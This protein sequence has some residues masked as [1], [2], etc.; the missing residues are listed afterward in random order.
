MKHR[1]KWL[2]AFIGGLSVIYSVSV[3][4]FVATCP[5]LRMRCLLED[6][7]EGKGIVIQATPDVEC[8]GP[9]P[10]PGDILLEIRRQPI[11]SFVDFTAQLVDLRN[12]PIPPGGQLYAGSDPSEL[13]PFSLP[14][15]VEDGDGHRWVEIEFRNHDTGVVENSW[16]MVQSIPLADL[17][18]TFVWFLLQL[19]IFIIGALAYW[20]RPFDRPARMFF[21]MCIVTLAGFVGGFHWWVVAGNLWLN[22]PFVICAALVPVVTLHFFLIFPHPKPHLVKRPRLV[23]TA[24]YALPVFTI[25][26]MIAMMAYLQVHSGNE[27]TPVTREA[28]QTGQH[29][30]RIVIYAY[31]LAAAVYFLLTMVALV[32]SFFTTRNPVEH[33]QVK[34][35][36]W[37]GLAATLPVSY[38]L[39]LAHFDRVGFALGKARVPMFV[40]S[41]SFMLAYAVGM[42]RFKLMLADQIISKGVLYYVVS[43]SVALGFSLI[44]ACTVIVAQLLTI[45]LSPQ[46]SFAVGAVLVMSLLL[47]LWLRDRFQQMT[48]RKFFREKYQLDKAL[49]RMNR[50]VGHLGTPDVVADRM[51]T[52]CRDVLRI[53]QAG[54]YLRTSTDNMFQLVAAQG[55]EQIPM[56]LIV[57]PE[58]I[59]ELKI[60]GTLQRITTGSRNEMSVVQSTLR[61][62]SAEL[63]HALEA[64]DD[65][66]GFVA[67]GSKDNSSA[68]TGEDVT[69]LHAMGQITHVALHSAKVHSDVT[70]LNEDL[71][72]KM[73]RIATQERHIS[74]LQSE[75]ATQIEP[76]TTLADKKEGA[77]FRRE[78][79]RGNSPAIRNVLETV[80]KVASSESTVLVRGESGTGKELLAKILHD[81]S[82]RREGPIVQVHCASLSPGLLES[83]LFGHAKGSFTGAHRDKVGRFEMA[84]RGT[85]FLDEIGDISMETQI[86]LLRVLQERCFEPVGSSRT[87]HV[88]V[89]LITATHQPLERLISEGSFR[90]DLYYRLNVISVTLPPLRERVEDIIDLALHFLKRAAHRSDKSITHIDE[91]ALAAM[92]F[93]SWPGNVRQLENVIERAVVL[94]EGGRIRLQDLPMEISA[95]LMQRSRSTLAD[96]QPQPPT[97]ISQPRRL[98]PVDLMTTEKRPSP[99]SRV[100]SQPISPV[101]STNQLHSSP[102]P[103]TAFS[104]E[105]Q[106][107][108]TT[109]RQDTLS[110]QPANVALEPDQEKEMLELALEKAEGNKAKAARMMGLPR[111]TYYSKLKKYGIR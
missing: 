19:G 14:P 63:I 42:I 26:T 61:R 46:Q 8:K 34:W 83:E 104:L 60:D 50:T 105:S 29:L 102:P 89:R 88:D 22:I 99:I 65:I 93:F 11:L 16:L 72:A 49:E 68:F 56:Q 53:E 82:P 81:N 66:I 48:D 94:A 96:A 40:A 107:D 4:G 101:P 78:A 75:L 55:S 109:N 10:V 37:A 39:F 12:A 97:S 43:W 103:M 62:L 86:K 6:T 15:L 80:R 17:M 21:V 111:S 35:I 32:Y 73:E 59:K 100:D 54:L 31:F 52:T 24:M 77:G 71:R 25:I 1:S 110:N 84:D 13:G 44:V 33:S 67:L 92:E 38:T 57:E 87:V 51:L 90:E 41:V 18:L 36:L 47:L 9:K 5:D 79:M 98:A 74:M 2:M 30:L 108:R 7:E 76:E 69:F 3:L 58:F 95:E 20:H 91:D 23:I 27:S 45:S 85:L 64:D 70:R 106:P 28:L